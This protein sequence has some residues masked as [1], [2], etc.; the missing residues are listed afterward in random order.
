MNSNHADSTVSKS[1]TL[2]T[3]S[4]KS[5]VFTLKNYL[6]STFGPLFKCYRYCSR[7]ANKAQTPFD[8]N[9]ELAF[10]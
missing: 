1:D 7:K 6:S 4:K 2:L 10:S 5:C 8:K 9:K 3:S